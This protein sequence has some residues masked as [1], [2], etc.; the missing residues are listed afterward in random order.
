MLALQIASFYTTEGTG[1]SGYFSSAGTTVAVLMSI[2][3]GIDKMESGGY[4]TFFAMTKS[5]VTHSYSAA[6]GTPFPRVISRDKINDK[7]N[8]L[9][10]D[11]RYEYS[12]EY[13]LSETATEVC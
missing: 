10:F 1:R 3:E 6:P 9:R 8:K 4:T 12:Y 5:I 11:K 7:K 13:C 2:L